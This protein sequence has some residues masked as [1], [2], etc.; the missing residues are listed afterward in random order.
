MYHIVRVLHLSE[1]FIYYSIVFKDILIS[2]PEKN[3]LAYI[4]MHAS[5]LVLVRYVTEK[6]DVSCTVYIKLFKC[7]AIFEFKNV[8]N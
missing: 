3:M 7:F 1:C 5:Y 8:K 4:I 2:K 6:I